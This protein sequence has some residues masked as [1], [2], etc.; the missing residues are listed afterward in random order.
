MGWIKDA[1]VNQMTIEANKALAAGR[2]VMAVKLNFP[3]SKPDFSGEIV[4]WSMMIE[5]IE[6]VGWVLYNFSSG[7]DTKGRPEAM[8]LFRVRT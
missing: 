1:K 2:Q 5:A 8:C 6:S 3:S 4:D 7:S